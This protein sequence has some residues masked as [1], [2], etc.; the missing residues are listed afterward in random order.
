MGI[1]EASGGGPAHQLIRTSPAISLAA[2]RVMAAVLWPVDR[3]LW[4]TRQLPHGAGSIIMTRI[5]NSGR[6]FS[7]PGLSGYA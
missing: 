3:L 6:T 5:W 1:P 7:M 2:I 4:M